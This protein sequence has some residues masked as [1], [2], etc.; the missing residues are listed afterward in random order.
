[1]RFMLL[2]MLLLPLQGFALSKEAKEFMSISEALE[3]VHCEK[4][5]LTR[6]IALAE[7]EKRPE[8]I[9]RLRTRLAALDDDPKVAR[10]ERRLAELS[11]RLER[12]S[13]AEDLRAINQQR[14]EAFYRCE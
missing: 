4:R 6:A 14:V 8:E 13:D 9:R 7:I 10:L 12:S 11:P 1:M 3:P 2:V 5:K